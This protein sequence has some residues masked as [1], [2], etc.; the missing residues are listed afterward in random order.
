MKI[1]RLWLIFSLLLITGAMGQERL[2]LDQA[3]ELAME[4]NYA[5][6]MARTESQISRN[7]F[8]PGNAGM[9]PELAATASTT[10]SVS[11]SKQTYVTGNVID[12][13]NAV[14]D[15]KNLAL[16]FN[17]TL[18]DGLAMFANLNK[19]R[20]FRDMGELEARRAVETTLNEVISAYYDILRQKQIQ[21]SL[22]E[23]VTISEQR[24]RISE[25]KHAMGSESRFDLLNARV[26]L[27]Q[28]RSRLMNQ[29]ISL[30]NARTSLN[31]LLGRAGDLH[32]E[33]VDT[34]S[35]SRRL[36]LPDLREGLLQHNT[37]LL[38]ARK[39]HR[40]AE[41]DVAAACAP[42]LPRLGVN[43]GYTIARSESQSGLMHS[44]KSHGYNYGVN[45]S[46]TLFDGFSI[47]RN[48]QNARVMERSQALRVLELQN[49]LEAELTRLFQH[50]QANMALIDIER[51]NV[52]VARE[53]VAI[54]MEKYRLGSVSALQMRDIQVK[55][56]DAE[57]RL[58]SAQYS[59]KIHEIQ[60]LKLSGELV[61]LEEKS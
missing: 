33:V 30:N 10:H 38:W 31:E 14:S 7:N 26:D 34:I 12:R 41:F 20:E 19:L 25:A 37:D 21:Q 17:W 61:R 5:I 36:T 39:N 35:F 56:L 53:N 16:N 8:H 29:E 32:F 27:N 55:Y 11:N 15:A 48:R 47:H 9:L 6:R 45:A 2:T 42:M 50:Y 57:S 28:D 4:H 13:T 1:E 58:I 22:E 49:Q 46:Y 44:N 40:A 54:S 59:A 52:Q 18:F 24:M 51:E 60:L 3:I 23:A 43:V